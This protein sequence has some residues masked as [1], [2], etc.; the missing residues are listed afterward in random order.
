MGFNDGTSTKSIKIFRNLT[1]HV[2][3]CKAPS[4]ARVV[5]TLAWDMLCLVYPVLKQA[6]YEQNIQMLN[7]TCEFDYSFSLKNLHGQMRK[8]VFTTYDPL[9]SSY[10]GAIAKFPVEGP[11]KPSNVTIMMFASGNVAFSAKSLGNILQAYKFL[12]EFITDE[13]PNIQSKEPILSKRKLEENT[14]RRKYTLKGPRK[15]AR[16][17]CSIT[18]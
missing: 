15:N 5:A 1:L 8:Q 11:G 10:P 3:G 14:P 6:V 17:D 9:E 13:K 12:L 4:E 18:I 16:I 2:T 7:A